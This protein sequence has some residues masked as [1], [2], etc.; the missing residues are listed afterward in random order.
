M[1]KACNTIHL[2]QIVFGAAA[3]AVKR[4]RRPRIAE[5]LQ[6]DMDSHGHEAEVHAAFGEDADALRTILEVDAQLVVGEEGDDVIG[7]GVDL[8]LGLG[9]IDAAVVLTEIVEVAGRDV[10]AGL[11][12]GADGE[13]AEDE[14]ESQGSGEAEDVDAAA[15]L[16]Q[17]TGLNL[18]EIDRLDQMVVVLEK[19]GLLGT[20]VV[21]I[22]VH[23]QVDAEVLGREQVQ[24]DQVHE[25]L[26]REGGLEGIRLHH[27]IAETEVGDRI[28]CN[29][30][31]RVN[32][33]LRENWQGEKGHEGRQKH[34]FH[35]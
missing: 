22:Q 11:G 33:V 30:T 15:G 4:K 34:S 29:G 31:V 26:G 2:A 20:D 8:R 13:V 14:L 28:E 35:T 21:P 18:G 17:G 7:E 16:G 3:Q 10:V 1:G 6:A 27:V 32:G 12:T 9:D 25:E 24:L 5:I 19:G 23:A